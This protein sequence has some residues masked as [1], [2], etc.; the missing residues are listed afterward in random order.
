MNKL[1]TVYHGSKDVIDE[2][3]EEAKVDEYY[4]LRK[5]RNDEANRIYWEMF[6]EEDDG[7]Y[8]QDIIRG[9]IKNDDPRIPRNVR[10]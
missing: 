5:N 7:I 2:G 3:Y 1:V 6:D 8:I 10:V 4:E 9:G